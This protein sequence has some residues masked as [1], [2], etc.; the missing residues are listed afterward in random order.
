MWGDNMAKKSASVK[1]EKKEV[2]K[3][4]KK[5]PNVKKLHK[6]IQKTEIR[7]RKKNQKMMLLNQKKKNCEQ[8]LDDLK[9]RC[10]DLE[11]LLNEREQMIS[12]LNTDLEDKYLTKINELTAERK[13]LLTKIDDLHKEIAQKEATIALLQKSEYEYQGLLS[14]DIERVKT[15]WVG[16]P[17]G[18]TLEEIDLILANN[19]SDRL[20]DVVLDIYLEDEKGQSYKYD[21]YPVKAELLPKEHISRKIHLF[22]H[23]RKRGYYKLTIKVYANQ[24]KNALAE[25][26]KVFNI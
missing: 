19:S 8:E 26:T 2:K 5:E 4:T 7:L 21:N 10:K 11:Y 16:W 15:N 24:S 23:L 14:L 9:S 22:K 12:N 18:A 20:T 13:D 6:T 3:T 1:K 25:Q 17:E